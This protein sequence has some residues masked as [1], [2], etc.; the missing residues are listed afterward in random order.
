[1]KIKTTAAII[2][3]PPLFAAR[4]AGAGATTLGALGIVMLETM[5]RDSMTVS[6]DILACGCATL[7]GCGFASTDAGGVVVTG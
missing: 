1:M 2:K 5:S 6:D 3:P 4:G 7:R